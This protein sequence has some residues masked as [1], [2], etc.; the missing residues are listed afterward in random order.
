M[1]AIIYIITA[2]LTAATVAAVLIARRQVFVVPEGFYG[3]LYHH[4][5]S[6]HR[7]SPGRHCFWSHSYQ[8]R[9][10]DMRNTILDVPGQEVLSMD[11]VGLKI[12]AVL[13]YQIIQA[14]KAVHEVQ[15]YIAHLQ[16]VTQVAIRS[17]IGA[18]PIEALVNQRRDIRRQ[19]F[20]LVHS[21]ADRIGIVLHDLVVKDMVFRDELNKVSAET[22]KR[23]S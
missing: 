22:R 3:L 13:T 15:D 17:V 16:N 8:V 6:R 12:G 7:I 9:L 18:T 14:E 2:A 21:E 1:N 10:V 11:N 5:K 4:G 20:A 19:L 23:A